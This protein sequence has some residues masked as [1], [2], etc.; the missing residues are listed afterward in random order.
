MESLGNN[1][2]LS[3]D[4]KTGTNLTKQ[5]PKVPEISLRVIGR[6]RLVTHV[7]AVTP[8]SCVYLFLISFN[9]DLSIFIAEFLAC[10]H[11]FSGLK[12]DKTAGS[13]SAT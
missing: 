7:Q 5:T 10:F 8:G 6:H 9:I 12:L 13:L 2:T 3:F 11:V 4:I 1:L